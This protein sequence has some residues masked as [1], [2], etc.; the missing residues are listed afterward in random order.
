MTETKYSYLITLRKVLVLVIEIFLAGLLVVATENPNWMF[1]VPLAEG[2]K[3]YLKVKV[4]VKIP[5]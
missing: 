5:F 1:L 4:G 2:I 3:N